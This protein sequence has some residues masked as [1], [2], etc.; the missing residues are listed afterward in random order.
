MRASSAVI[1]VALMSLSAT[2]ATASFLTERQLESQECTSTAYMLVARLTVSN[3]PATPVDVLLYP[4]AVPQLNLECLQVFESLSDATANTVLQRSC[5]ASNAA[6]S[7][8]TTP[9]D[10]AT[11]LS[12]A[13]WTCQ[14]LGAYLKTPRTSTSYGS[15]GGPSLRV[16]IQWMPQLTNAQCYPRDLTVQMVAYQPKQQSAS[17]AASVVFIIV[18]CLVGLGVVG[19]ALYQIHK[20]MTGQFKRAE[21]ERN[22]PMA[23]HEELAMADGVQRALGFGSGN[24]GIDGTPPPMRHDGIYVDAD[25]VQVT[26]TEDGVLESKPMPKPWYQRQNYDGKPQPAETIARD[27]EEDDNGATPRGRVSSVTRRR[28]TPQHHQGNGG[29]SGPRRPLAHTSEDHAAQR[30][31]LPM[32]SLNRAPV[33]QANSLRDQPSSEEEEEE[34]VLVCGDCNLPI[35]DRD[36][37]KFCQI[38]GMR[39]Y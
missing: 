5:A 20:S 16:K 19:F 22:M 29:A 12:E 26:V 23:E 36:T 33:P 10:A 32:R 37:P 34:T 35:H 31:S 11:P 25:E 28:Y 1:A 24:G 7:V 3:P 39:H 8:C 4:D 27:D 6:L 2:L 17:I 30:G 9:A 13:T 15:H 14:A 38:T 18:V 21:L